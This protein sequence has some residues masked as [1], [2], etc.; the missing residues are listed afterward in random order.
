MELT[1]QE[2]DLLRQ[3]YNAVQDLA[4]EYLEPRDHALATKIMV[5][6]SLAN[7]VASAIDNENSR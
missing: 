6:L 4:P 7:A 1:P 2:L 5:A 3:W